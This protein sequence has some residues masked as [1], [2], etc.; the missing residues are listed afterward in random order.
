M[1]LVVAVS[2]IPRSHVH[3]HET[4]DALGKLKL[5]ASD[6][7][8]GRELSFTLPEVR[9]FK[10]VR[11]TQ[12]WSG[13]H[14]FQVGMSD[15]NVVGNAR[16]FMVAMQVALVEDIFKECHTVTYKQVLNDI[17]PIN[18]HVVVFS[19]A[20]PQLE[21]YVTKAV[22]DIRVCYDPKSFYNSGTLT[23]VQGTEDPKY[24]TVLLYHAYTEVVCDFLL[25]MQKKMT[26]LYHEVDSAVKEME[27]AAEFKTIKDSMVVVDDVL[28]ESAES[29]G[30]IR[31]ARANMGFKRAAFRE[32]HFTGVEKDLIDALDV[33]YYF[34]ALIS[35]ADYAIA[36]WSDVLIEYI[37]NIDATL[38]A[39]LMLLRAEKGGKG[40]KWPF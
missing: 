8:Y 33:D 25:S 29:Y 21:G 37:K 38:E 36:L 34:T 13:L 35:D 6:V 18:F 39:R 3:L 1:A 30:K 23:Y 7:S 26:R 24:L 40:G 4:F 17:I 2:W 10:D 12:E 20:E 31:Q 28:K 22:R 11:F 9:G 15:E 19:N 14:Y 32:E 27:S 16:D 5:G